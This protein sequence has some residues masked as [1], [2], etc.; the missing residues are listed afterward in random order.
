L[1]ERS[2]ALYEDLGDRWSMA[3]VLRDLGRAA[4]LAS[5]YAEVSQRIQESLAI[6]R[7]LGDRR[8][9]S[10]ASWW[11]SL[12]ALSLGDPGRAEQLARE[13][14]VIREELG[15]RSSTVRW[16]LANA[17]HLSGRYDEAH[18]LMEEAMAIATDLG[19]RVQ[20][21]VY[22]PEYQS[23]LEMDRGLYEQARALAE[24]ALE[25]AREM[26]SWRDIGF[27]LCILGSIALAEGAHTEAQRLLQ[28]SI[29]A[30]REIKKRDE[31][32]WA[33]A[34]AGVA[35]RCTGHPALARRY[36][37]KALRI[38][39]ETGTFRP[40]IT[41]VPAMALLFLDDGEIERA[42][43]LYALASR[44]PYVACS[45]WLEDVAGKHIAA[46]AAGLPADVVAAAQDRGRAR[47]M[48]ATVKELLV[49]LC[50]E[51]ER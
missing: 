33:L 18:S 25:V 35:A 31:L 14:L 10:A 15:G 44:Y 17:L 46:M 49:E 6:F 24:K 48:D 45:H 7:S 27:T 2:L 8:G 51:D 32:G 23:Y 4:W 47:D 26:R 50:Q 43:E 13:S 34:C 42:V 37:C 19:D 38:G 5:D 22:I 39:C 29:A 9:I 21:R 30:Y 3:G 12:I 36:L 11:L 16:M 20:S 28:E 41:P 40:R 1:L